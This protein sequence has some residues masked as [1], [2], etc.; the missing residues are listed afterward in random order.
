MIG[1]SINMLRWFSSFRNS[2]EGIG[3]FLCLMFTAK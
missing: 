2:K 1:R 3:R